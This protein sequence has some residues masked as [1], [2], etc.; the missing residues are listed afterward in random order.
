MKN[1]NKTSVVPPTYASVLEQIKNDVQQSQLR[2]AQSITREL[3]LLY[4]RIGKMLTEKATEEGWGSKTLD[5][6]SRDLRDFFPEATG[7]SLRNFQF[8]ALERKFREKELEQ[9]LIGHIQK[10]LLELGEGFAFV[11]RQYKIEVSGKEYFI[12]L[13]FYHLKL[14]CY[15]VVELCGVCLEGY[16]KTYRCSGLSSKAC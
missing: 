11:G 16:S 4:W 1:L 15:I 14:R 7:F 6:L 2:A 13:L 8:L 10:F 12:D 5:R 9:G 3:I